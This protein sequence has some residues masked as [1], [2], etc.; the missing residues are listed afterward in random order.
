MSVPVLDQNMLSKL[1]A[2]L[3]DLGEGAYSRY[4]QVS[5]EFQRLLLPMAN[6]QQGQIFVPIAW[7]GMIRMIQELEYSRM[8]MLQ[9]AKLRE[10]ICKE[11][12]HRNSGPPRTIPPKCFTTEYILIHYYIA[13]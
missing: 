4:S 6:D 11:I 7:P 2:H 9:D 8:F 5:N 3:C 13:R 1:Q 10:T 12:S